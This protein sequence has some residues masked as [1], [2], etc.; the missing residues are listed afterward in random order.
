MPQGSA[1]TAAQSAPSASP[2]VGAVFA[3]IWLIFMLGAAVTYVIMLIAGWRLM[4][5][6]EKIAD[7]LSDIAN[8]MH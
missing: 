5:A 4:K 2:V 3:I 7:K 1:V 6:H 8:K